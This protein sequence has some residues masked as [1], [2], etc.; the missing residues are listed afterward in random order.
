MKNKNQNKMLS[1]YTAS[2]GTERRQILEQGGVWTKP[3]MYMEPKTQYKRCRQKQ[4]VY[5]MLKE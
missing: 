3:A 4:E 5:R 1:C 2:H